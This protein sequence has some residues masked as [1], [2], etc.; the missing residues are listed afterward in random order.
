MTKPMQ[1]GQPDGLGSDL[2]QVERSILAPR[3]GSALI[4]I[5]AVTCRTAKNGRLLTG[6]CDG[7]RHGRCQ[8]A[9]GAAKA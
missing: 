3:A 1:A 4:A 8:D 9:T 6:R 5:E 7:R 2:E